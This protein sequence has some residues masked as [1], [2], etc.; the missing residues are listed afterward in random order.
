VTANIVAWQ[1]ERDLVVSGNIKFRGRWSPVA[2]AA[3]QIG[4]Q[5]GQQLLQEARALIS[6]GRFES[7]IQQLQLVVHMDDQPDLVSQAKPLF[8]SACQQAMSR[9]NQRRKTLESDV[10]SA[11][12]H[13]EQARQTLTKAEASLRQATGGTAPSNTQTQAAV[14]T[15][16]RDLDSVQNDLG[17]VARQLDDVVLRITTLQSIGAV[18]VTVPTVNSQP[19]PPPTRPSDTLDALSDIVAWLKRNWAAV[20]VIGLALMFLL[21]RFIKD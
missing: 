18:P 2:E 15:A 12:Q 11:Q 16:R 20:A 10:A 14:D 3:R 19:A 5:R 13:M 21:S 8:D 9:L 1:A 7:A 17:R 4:P 6:Q